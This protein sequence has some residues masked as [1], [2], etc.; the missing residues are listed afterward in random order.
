[1]HERKQHKPW[2]DEECLGISDQ[3]KQAKMQWIQDPSQSNVDSLTNVRLAAS[4]H[5][6]N[7]K[8]DYLKAK[9]KELESNSKINNIRDLYRGINNVKKAYQPRT[10]TVKDEKDDLVGDSQSIMARWRNYI[11]LI[12]NVH[13]VSDVRQAEIHTT[14]ILASTGFEHRLS[15]P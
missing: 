3:W 7:K 14:E 6:R 8:K 11:S 10:R 15:N 4:R 13:G 2:F 1:M 5:F 12:L 9:I